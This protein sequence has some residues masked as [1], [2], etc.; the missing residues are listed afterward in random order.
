MAPHL[1]CSSWFTSSLFPP[2]PHLPQ[3]TRVLGPSIHTLFHSTMISYS[4][5]LNMSPHS[6]TL[7]LVHLCPQA[8]PS[9]CVHACSVIQSDSLQPYRLQPARLLCPWDFPGKN[10]GVSCHFLLQGI[11]PTQGSNPCFLS[12]LHWQVGSLPLSH[13]GN[14]AIILSDFLRRRPSFLNNSIP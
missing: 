3:I 10:T 8:L 11:F 6:K 7:V 4:N 12:L 5:L 1:L 14:P 9:S 2:F 13:L